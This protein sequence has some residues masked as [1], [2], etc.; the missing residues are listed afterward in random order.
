M[1]WQKKI[2]FID[3]MAIEDPILID[4]VNLYVDGNSHIPNS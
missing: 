3:L 4:I 2:G 1:N